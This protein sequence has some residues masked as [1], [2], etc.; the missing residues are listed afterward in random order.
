MTPPTRGK[1]LALPDRAKMAAK[2]SVGPKVHWVLIGIG[3]IVAIYLLIK[4]WP[5]AMKS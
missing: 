5:F 2:R 1:A 3:L 4:F